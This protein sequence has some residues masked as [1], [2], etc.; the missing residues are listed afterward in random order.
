MAGVCNKPVPGRCNGG[1]PVVDRSQLR[2]SSG[3]GLG[4]WIVQRV[5]A[6]YLLV[7]CVS[8]CIVLIAHPIQSHADW[9]SL[10]S[11]ALFRVA[12]IL[13]IASL[14]IH[15]WTGIRSVFLDYVHN[16]GVR[17]VLMVILAL[18]F[19]GMFAWALI[20]IGVT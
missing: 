7:F 14:I 15:A 19:S 12:T 13:F 5:S 18:L 2:G 6:V 20:V 3:G 16:W 4:E 8:L 10:S 11:G 17:F 1:R 9:L